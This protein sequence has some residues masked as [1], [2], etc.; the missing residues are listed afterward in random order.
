[1]KSAFLILLVFLSGCGGADDASTPAVAAC[2]PH[3]PV[4]I[5]LFG[6]STQAGYTTTLDGTSVIVAHNPADELQAYFTGLY[7]AGKVIVSSRAVGGTTAKELVAGTD[8][9]NAPWPGSVMADIVVVNHGIN[10]LTH[11]GAVLE[12]DP[13]GYPKHVTILPEGLSSYRAALATL[14]KAPAVV[15]FETPNAVKVYDIAPYAQMMRDVAAEQGLA[16]ADTYAF[17]VDKTDQLSDWA[18]PT[19]ALYASIAAKVVE[20]VVGLVVAAL[21]C[22]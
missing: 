22:K 4:V 1:M 7:G 18:H 6:D 11:D 17:T 3:D 21:L 12:L 8:H 9:L 10:D 16:V 13:D 2:V 15:I 14:A 20:P 19:D 5:Q